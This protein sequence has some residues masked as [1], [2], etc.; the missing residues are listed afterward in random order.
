MTLISECY[1]HPF[2]KPILFYQIGEDFSWVKWSSHSDETLGDCVWASSDSNWRTW[3]VWD[4]NDVDRNALMCMKGT[5]DLVATTPA[6]S[7]VTGTCTEVL[8][9]SYE[10]DK[11][12][13]DSHC[14]VGTHKTDSGGAYHNAY[15]CCSAC[16]QEYGDQVQESVF[17]YNKVYFIFNLHYN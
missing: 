12:W 11:K 17:N 6:P 5:S 3:R 14:T 2:L 7:S 1:T 10:S 15:S 4:C 8:T 16:K 9:T 13:K